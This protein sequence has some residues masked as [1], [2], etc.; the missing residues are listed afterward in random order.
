MKFDNNIEFKYILFDVQERSYI[1][2]EVNLTINKENALTLSHTTTII[3]F[4]SLKPLAHKTFS[5]SVSAL[6]FAI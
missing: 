1:A 3:Q 2:I 5:L 6:Q 4:R